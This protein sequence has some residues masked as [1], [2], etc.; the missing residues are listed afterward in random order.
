MSFVNPY[1][2]DPRSLSFTGSYVESW[3]FSFILLLVFVLY[4]VDVIFVIFSLSLLSLLYQRAALRYSS[5]RRSRG[6]LLSDVPTNA[7]LYR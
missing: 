4:E 1:E 5:S 2:P 3:R 6:F 7:F